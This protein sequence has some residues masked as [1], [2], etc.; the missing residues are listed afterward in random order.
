MKDKY[1]KI[2]ID[3][4]RLANLKEICEY[5][6]CSMSE[7]VRDSID[8]CYEELYPHCTHTDVP[9]K[10]NSI[11]SKENV[12]TNVPTED[13]PPVGRHADVVITDDTGDFSEEF[14][15]KQ[16]TDYGEFIDGKWTPYVK[17]EVNPIPPNSNVLVRKVD[18]ASDPQP[19]IKN[20]TFVDGVLDNSWSAIKLRARNG[21]KYG[22]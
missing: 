22:I 20:S 18:P 3:E 13:D 12:P 5:D 2:R 17:G 21:E 4:E 19:E 16:P 1:L 14:Q 8:L 15:G 7:F 11:K 10:D 6:N 9:T